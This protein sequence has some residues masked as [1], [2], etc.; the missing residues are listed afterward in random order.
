[1]CKMHHFVQAMSYT[2]SI[3]ILTVISLERYVAIIHPMRSKQFQT[4]WLLRATVVGV[5]LVAACS[6]IPQLVVYDTLEIPTPDGSTLS[7]CMPLH[8]FNAKAYTVASF[9]LWYLIPLVWM[10][11]VYG[12]VSVVLWR[13][14]RNAELKSST[15]G[16]AA[17]MRVGCPGVGL[18]ASSVSSSSARLANRDSTTGDD[19]IYSRLRRTSEYPDSRRTR[20]SV[21]WDSASVSNTDTD[22]RATRAS[23]D[24][25]PYERPLRS[26]V[27]RSGSVLRSIPSSG[28][29]RS[30]STCAGSQLSM[31]SKAF[32]QQGVRNSALCSR[33][34][35]IRLLVAI[36]V[37]FALCVLPYHVRVLWMSFDE[38]NLGFWHLLV[39]PLTFV[40]YY[41]NSGLNPML[42]AFLSEKFRA[43]LADLMRCRD[44]RQMRRISVT[45]RTF[46]SVA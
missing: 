14:S 39:P 12:R 18:D 32:A 38:P 10:M 13:S 1:M 23:E 8:P 6:G 35:V 16:R 5:W 17:S 34:K 44:S 43:S 46:N 42:Y 24:Q 4:M 20:N 27:D 41:A 3:T 25:G 22:H 11:L 19:C 40:L 33:R 9:L 26:S 7:F 30:G 29:P 28:T 2:A 21:T 45:M 31:R 15:G 36:V 37:T